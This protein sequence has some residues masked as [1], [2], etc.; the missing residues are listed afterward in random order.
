MVWLKKN[1]AEYIFHDFKKEKLSPEKIKQWLS[2]Q[3]MNTL[4]NKKSAAW[5][6][7]SEEQKQKAV[8]EKGAIDLILQYSNLIKR[9]V[10]EISGTILIGFEEQEYR[11]AL[12]KT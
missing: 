12:P 3:P 9:P 10:A 6:M 5:R 4:L 11:K 7:L 8:T 1:H 2:V